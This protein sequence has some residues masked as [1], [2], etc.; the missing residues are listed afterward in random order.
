MPDNKA[1]LSDFVALATLDFLERGG[2]IQV[3]PQGK[4]G[5]R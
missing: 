1:A 4:R 5:L 2:R 3:I